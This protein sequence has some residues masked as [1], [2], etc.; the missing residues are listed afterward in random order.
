[1]KGKG[2]E[3]KKVKRGDREYTEN[4]L[5]FSKGAC[6][7]IKGFKKKEKKKAFAGTAVAFLFLFCLIFPF[8]GKAAVSVAAET[9]EMAGMAERVCSLSFSPLPERAFGGKKEEVLLS[10]FTTKFDGTNLPRSHNIRLAG[11]LIDGC[12]LAAGEEFSFNR[13]V[14]KRTAARGFQEAP[15]IFDGKFTKGTGGGVC[16]VSTTLYNAA[17]LAGMKIEEAHPHSLQVGYVRPSLDAMVSS[18]SDLR[19]TNPSGAPAVIRMYADENSITAEIYGRETGYEYRTE[20]AVLRILPPPPAEEV[21]GEEDCVLRREKNGLKSESY[22]VCYRRGKR[23]K[24]VRLRRD[25]YAWVQGKLQKKR[26]ECPLLPEDGTQGGEQT[27][28]GEET[29]NSFGKVVQND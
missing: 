18:S 22:L 8:G 11:K 15:V 1:M 24:S 17:L 2:G 28:G 4:F 16:Q 9:A 29:G 7:K 13:R 27:D 25:T 19:F 5:Q 12:R 20:S 14:G 21:E 10:R 26:E 3:V 6:Q 23:L